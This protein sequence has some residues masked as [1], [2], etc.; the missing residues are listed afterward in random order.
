MEQTNAPILPLKS[1]LINARPGLLLL[2]LIL[3]LIAFYAFL[4]ITTNSQTLQSSLVQLTQVSPAPTSVNETSNWTTYT[5]SLNGFSLK[6]PSRWQEEKNCQGKGATDYTCLVSSDFEQLAAGAIMGGIIKGE[7][8]MVGADIKALSVSDYCKSTDSLNLLWCKENTINSLKILERKINPTTIQ[9][10]IIR[11]NQIDIQLN[12]NFPSNSENQA[13]LIFDQILQTFKFINQPEF[14]D[15]LEYNNNSINFYYPKAWTI[16]EEKVDT[17]TFPTIF[18]N[19][20]DGDLNISSYIAFGD[21]RIFSTSCAIDANEPYIGDGGTISFS[22]IGKSYYV[23]IVELQKYVNGKSTGLK[24]YRFQ[25]K[26]GPLNYV[27]V[28]FLDLSDK[29]LISQI[30]STFKF[31]DQNS[32]EILCKQNGES[33]CINPLLCPNNADKCCTGLYAVIDSKSNAI[34]QIPSASNFGKPRV[35]SLEK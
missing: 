20:N 24:Y 1:K 12:F 8:I 21:C 11:D 10:G 17:D 27:T 13:V 33:I 28:Q 31:I 25:Q 6:Y 30:L 29:Y 34:C 14:P 3:L 23:K 2:L 9:A 19:K 4:T 35:N 22:V 16:R 5:D 32:I 26:L 15:W 7:L 18:I